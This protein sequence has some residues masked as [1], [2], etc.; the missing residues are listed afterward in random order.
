VKHEESVQGDSSFND[1]QNM[2]FI[3]SSL[4]QVAGANDS[5]RPVR[6]SY[7]YNFLGRVKCE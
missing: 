6:P 7:L 3:V 4:V 1:L 5:A 2:L